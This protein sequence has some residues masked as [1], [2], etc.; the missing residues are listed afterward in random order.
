MSDNDMFAPLRPRKP[1]KASRPNVETKQQAEPNSEEAAA[2]AERAEA[3]LWIRGQ[4]AE[5]VPIAGTR[6][7]R[8]L[9]EHRGLRGP[10]WPASLRWAERYRPWPAAPPR[11]CLLATVTNPA[12]EIVAVHS[13]EID[14]ATGEK[15]RRNDRPKMSRG[16]V[17]E[18]AVFLGIE[19]EAA[20]VMALGEG[21]ETTLT[22]RLVG[23]CDAYAC[24][25]PLRFI[26]PKQHHRRVE[27]LADTN[28]RS[29]ARRLAREYA[30]LGVPAYVVTVPDTLGPKADLNDALREMGETAVLMAI[31][32]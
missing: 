15:S 29:T 30:R 19:N 22:R 13:I 6:G 16:P 2:A 28:A 32:D 7:E 31:E 21:V 23:P 18:G 5:S 26:H 27:I 12:G 9:A 8:Y 11:A 17:S 20:S 25:G 3:V 24:L 10:V 4:V 14:P 1:K